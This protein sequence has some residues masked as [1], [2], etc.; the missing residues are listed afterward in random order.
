V[1]CLRGIVIG[2]EDSVVGDADI[3]FKSLEEILRQMAC[4]PLSH[5]QSESFTQLMDSSLCD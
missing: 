1:F 5:R 2:D 3:A 4:V